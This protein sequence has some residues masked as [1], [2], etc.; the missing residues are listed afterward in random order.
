MKLFLLLACLASAGGARAATLAGGDYA[1]AD[2]LPANGDVLSGTFVNVRLFQL[3]AG[4][5]VFAAAGVPL[6][7]YASTISLAGTLDASGRGQL[8]GASGPAGGA[9]SAGFG[10]GPA[11]T[12]GGTAGA[13]RKGGGG[14][15]DG[16][17]GGSGAGAGG[18]SGGTVYGSTGA[19]T[20]PLS[21]DDVF[22]GSGGGGGGGGSQIPGGGGAPGGGAIYLEAASMTVTGAILLQG[23]TA[24]AI[25]SG[26][27]S[28]PGAGGGGSGGGLLLRVT[29]ALQMSNA[30]VS[31]NGGNGGNDVDP[32]VCGT[33]DPGGAGGGGR[34][35][36]FANST[37]FASVSFST[38]AGSPGGTGGFCPPSSIDSPAP[39]AGAAGTVSFGV[40]ASSPSGFMAQTVYATSIT[41]T[42]SAGPSFGDAPA[43]SRAY[44]IFPATAT[45]PLSSPEL[46]SAAPGA[47]STGLTPNTTYYRFAT[48]FTDWGDSLPSNAVSTHTLAS[49]PAAAAAPFSA[50]GATALTLNWTAGSPANPAYTLYE[51]QSAL[52]SG[53][54]L[55]LEDGFAA[56]L[57]SAPSGLAPNTT[58]Y[59]RVR[60]VNIDGVPTAFTAVLSTA[61]LALAPSSPAVGPVQVTSAA[62]SWSGG[63]NPADTQYEAEVS[64]DNF[65]S[66][67]ASSDTLMTSAT[68]FGLAPGTQ[69]FFRAR[70]LNRDGVASAYSAVLSTRAGILTDTS[71]PSAPGQ[72]APDRAFSYDGTVGFAWSPA[73]SSVGILNYELL[74]GS[75]PGGNDVFNGVVAVASYT[76]T[77]LATGKTYYAQARARSNSGAVGPF[78]NVS[79]GVPVFQTAGTPAIPKPYAWPNPFN[80]AAGPVQIGF[81]LDAAADVSLRVYT[82][83]GGFLRE[84]TQHF[85]S[86]GNQIASW[87]G[88]DGSGRRAAPGGYIVVVKKSYA[89]RTDS[90]RVKVAVLY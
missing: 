64:S 68:F 27:G 47:T 25:T 28:I 7:V 2:L 49:V 53:F 51:I 1:G 83:Q 87:D 15:A 3:P 61:T 26:S 18:G 43:A 23:A 58:Y 31:A 88:N 77:G 41:W 74:I 30:L 19:V 86:G 36:V 79:A 37:A 59:F 67:V 8:G 70:A 42:W 69:Y 73:Q 63:A 71:P 40:I 62:F 38:A 66:L 14:G 55:G 78:S 81:S 17:A 89:G 12:G 82:L 33:A 5:T 48:A 57:S 24:S 65:F 54:T 60:A 75:F 76:A 90:Q 44:R 32:L 10:G 6:T 52:D 20:S 4:A 45:A 21:A 29:G 50:V 85:G 16:G 84:V 72:P 13:L 22:Q 9:G 39:S 11:G 35:K 80:P 46:V 56:A 34:I